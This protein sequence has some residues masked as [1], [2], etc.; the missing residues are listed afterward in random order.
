VATTVWQGIPVPGESTANYDEIRRALPDDRFI[1]FDL[2]PA[3]IRSIAVEPDVAAAWIAVDNH[4]NVLW[5]TAHAVEDSPAALRGCVDLIRTLYGT[6]PVSGITVPRGVIGS[7]PGQLQPRSRSDW[8]WWYTQD[9]STYAPEH[10]MSVLGPD[11]PRLSH[12]L[13][14]ASPSAPVRPGDPRCALWA[15]VEDD[16]SDIA[17]TGGLAGMLTA[18][19]MASGAAHFND[20]ATHPARRGT[21]IARSLCAQAADYLLDKGHLAV[22][23]GMYAGNESAR[24]VYQTLGFILGDSYS[25]GPL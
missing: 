3:A 6:A 20:V 9:R 11:D 22:T 13:D 8:D 12:L 21:G 25:S 15:G 4:R 23:L 14:L 16:G 10:P 2:N 7:L 18:L 24:R 5:L 17:D 19:Q 1:E